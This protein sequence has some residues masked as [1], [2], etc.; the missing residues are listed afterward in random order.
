MR[1]QAWTVGDWT[2]LPELH[3]LRARG[4][5]RHLEPKQAAVLSRLCA[6]PGELV[7]KSQLLDE[8]W[9]GVFVTEEVLT[10]TIYQLRRALGDSARH[11]R[12]IETIPKRGYRLVARIEAAS[13]VEAAPPSPPRAYARRHR[14]LLVAAAL[15][16]VLM[17][18]PAV[19]KM[20][21]ERDH[22]HA[23]ALVAEGEVLL[24]SAADASDLR[25]LRMFEQAA[26]ID[27]ML[28]R[29]WS[30]LA[31]ARW[32]LVA[33]GQ[34]S[35][36]LGLPQVESA[37]RRALTLDATLAAPWETLGAVHLSRWEWAEAETCLLRAIEANPEDAGAHARL[38]ELFLLTG[39]TAQARSRIEHALG[40][41]PASRRVLMTAGFIDTMLHDRD[42]AA[43][44]YRALLA[45]DPND[46]EA[47][48][49][50]EKVTAA[51]ALPGPAMT[52]ERIDHLLKKQPLRPAVVAGLFA[53]AGD[54]E[55]ALEWLRR[56]RAEKDLSLLLVRL[57]TRWTRL[58]GDARFRAVF[59]DVGF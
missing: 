1:P 58:H 31:A 43:R 15:L 38:A 10:N 53:E 18:L 26:G 34:M 54:T 8:I 42:A 35:P 20:S 5:E 52:V 36:D 41:G 27:P 25:S 47:R 28:A 49:L 23:A 7:S 59:D 39:R 48:R 12:Y 44:S 4:V 17:M 56:A 3:L 2:F 19:R 9:A 33:R 46:R 13:A 30:G 14:W 37:A 24:A 50:L 6:T 55:R 32:S 51:E 21:A 45:R 29:A 57:D 16:T 11:H 22:R 40:L